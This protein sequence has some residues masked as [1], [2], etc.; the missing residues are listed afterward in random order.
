PAAPAT[1][2]APAAPAAPPPPSSVVT[3][4]AKTAEPTKVVFWHSMGGRNEEA[5]KKIVD[6]FNASQKEVIVEPQYQGT[7]DDAITKLRATG[8]GSRPDIMQLYDVGTRWMI[9]SGFA[10]KVQD[11]IDKDKYDISDYEPNILAYYSLPDGLYSM[12]FNCSSPVIIYNKTA[13]EKAGLDL[14]T[15][16]SSFEKLEESAKIMKEKG[17]VAVGGSM[18]NYSWVFEQLVGIQDKELLD[19]GNGRKARATKTVIDENGAGLNILKG[20]KS[21][22]KNPAMTVWGKGTAESKKQFATGT[23]GFIFDSCSIYV[24]T[25]AAAEG[26]FEIAFAPLPKVNAGDTGGTSVGGGSLWMINN[27]DE[28]RAAAAW[29]FIKYATGAEV[30]AKW[31][32]GTGYLPIRKG[33]TELPE[34][35]TYCK[36][37]N[38]GM[39]VAVNSLRN[40]KPACAGSLMGVF[41]KARTIIENEV[42][43]MMNEPAATP[44]S[45]LEKICK[46]LNSEIE[47]YNK[48]N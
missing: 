26:K 38:Q 19:N 33:A 42:E 29:Q 22:S 9:D 48:T 15:A 10:L 7:Y 36:D 16:F 8:E 20:Y 41:P 24:D 23:V 14:N 37:V 30:Q 2:A 25:A 43:I 1:P 44:E 11:Y 12:P 27:G 21:A 5:L 47:M 6:G 35:V 18:T 3:E 46:Q 4:V 39:M 40:S 34:F 32:M 13:A 31:S 17:G 45:A 28:N